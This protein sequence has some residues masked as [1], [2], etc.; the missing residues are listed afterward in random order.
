[1]STSGSRA[2]QPESSQLVQQLLTERRKLLVANERLR[3]ELAELRA[4][5]S[6]PDP[7][8]RRL[9]DEN[10]RLRRELAAT[11]AQL[12][13]FEEGVQKAVALLESE[14]GT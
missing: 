1:M 13:V 14:R 10:G 7:G 11:R 6:G 12:E 4:R 9:E 5:E 8:L 3:L 2:G